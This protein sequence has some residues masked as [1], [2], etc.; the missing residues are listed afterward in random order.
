MT[1]SPSEGGQAYGGIELR[2]SLPQLSGFHKSTLPIIIIDMLTKS[3]QK[4]KWALGR[5]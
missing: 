1:K 2:W 4:V 5:A 3:E